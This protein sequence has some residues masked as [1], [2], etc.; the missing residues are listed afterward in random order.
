V[1]VGIHPDSRGTVGG[2]PPWDRRSIR[3]TT[4]RVRPARVIGAGG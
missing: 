4:L 1:A 3:V 2:F